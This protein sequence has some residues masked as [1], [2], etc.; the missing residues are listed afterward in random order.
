MDRQQ[1]GSSF[2]SPPH[3]VAL[4]AVFFGAIDLTVV[5]TILPSMISDLGIN[6]AD[7][8]RYIWVVNSYLIAYVVSI[9]LVGRLTDLVG[10]RSV[11]VAALLVFSVGSIWCASAGSLQDLVI[12][13]A[14]QGFGGGALL[15]IAL[16]VAARSFEGAQR[17]QAVGAVGALDTL[18]WVSGPVYGAI[19]ANRLTF[20]DEPWRLVFWI[21]VPLALMLFPA[22]RL[23]PSHTQDSTSRAQVR[24]LLGKLDIPGFVL[25][26]IFLVSANMALASG[27]EIGATAGRGLRAFGGTPNP[28]ADRIPLLLATASSALI[29]FAWRIRSG[30]DTFLPRRLLANAAY[31]ASLAAN[32][33][34]G[35]VLMTGMVNVPIIVAL[36]ESGSNTG[37]RSAILLAPFTLTI[38]ISSIIAGRLLGTWSTSQITSIGLVL[39]VFGNLSVFPL[40][41]YADYGWMAIG[42]GIAGAG[43]GLALTP[44]SA[45]ALDSSASTS[46]GVAAATLLVFRLLGMTIGIS[47]LTSLGVQRLQ[48]LTGEL[49]PIMQTDA[50][51]TAEYL[52]RQQEYIVTRAIP[53][54]VQV[55]QE[56]FVVAAIL[57]A[58]ALIAARRL[59]SIRATSST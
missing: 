34:L 6:T 59:S 43:I 31:R 39:T 12:A 2:R 4:I 58:C 56:T 21:N 25:L 50:E 52:I 20:V 23:L 22:A 30:H 18:G 32:A 24:S 5:A 29:V 53:L 51:S 27:G 7:I 33:L 3:I 44:L 40:L 26:T 45:T 37:V 1:V 9:P 38:A 35:T 14:I 46:Y 41:E 8:D 17:A 47:L 42:L 28:L 13:R 48:V 57:S 19:V 10:V 55:V 49:E 54:G 36:V 11:F 15:P 16:A